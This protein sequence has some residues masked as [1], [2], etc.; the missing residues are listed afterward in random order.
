MR[1]TGQRRRLFPA[2][3]TLLLELWGCD[4]TDLPPEYRDVAVPTA[5]LISSDARARGRA[6]FLEHCVLC[7]GERANGQGRRRIL[8]A[9]P[10][11][12]TDTRW[13]ERV[14]S[15]RVYYVVRE[16]IRG[17]PMPAWKIISEDQTWD[18]V[19]YVLSVAERGPEP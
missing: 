13:R 11:D 10:A 18:L 5:R 17:T 7:H 2:A 8:S 6:L 1:R 14:T 9:R 3:G 4:A 16:G 19:A 15:R 12:F